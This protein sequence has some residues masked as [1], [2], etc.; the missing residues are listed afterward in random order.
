MPVYTD[1][2]GQHSGQ[3]LWLA[4]P[5]DNGALTCETPFGVSVTTPY[6]VSEGKD[7]QGKLYLV[8]TNADNTMSIWTVNVPTPQ[9]CDF[10]GH[11]TL[12][13]VKDI[14]TDTTWGGPALVVSGYGSPTQPERF[15]LIWSGTGGTQRLAKQNHL[16]Q[17]WRRSQLRLHRQQDDSLLVIEHVRRLGR[18][19]GRPPLS[20]NCARED[21]RAQLPE[22]RGPG[23]GLTQRALPVPVMRR[24]VKIREPPRDPVVVVVPR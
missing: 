2:I 5:G 6:L 20:G 9:D 23:P 13:L 24:L 15:W 7:G 16:L 18:A 12:N 1:V 22:L 3:C 14:N 4:E 19:L 11:F 10:G 8:T 21:M 17:R